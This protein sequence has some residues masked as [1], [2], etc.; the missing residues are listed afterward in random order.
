M[1]PLASSSQLQ[2][3]YCQ[4]PVYGIEGLF[5]SCEAFV[6]V[7]SL[8]LHGIDRFCLPTEVIGLTVDEYIHRGGTSRSLVRLM[9]LIQISHG[10]ASQ[11]Y[12]VQILSRYLY[13]SQLL[14]NIF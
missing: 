9:N 1:Q 14:R 7:E 11:V 3:G 5:L 13:R 8:E 10:K 12:T 6:C 2:H 4:R